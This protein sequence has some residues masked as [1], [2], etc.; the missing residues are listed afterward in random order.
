MCHLWANMQDKFLQK[1][2]E[3]RLGM[4]K[5]QDKRRKKEDGE[6]KYLIQYSV[7]VPLCSLQ[8]KEEDTQRKENIE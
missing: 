1:N 5:I 6:E 3:G 2:C 8:R 4:V 7:V